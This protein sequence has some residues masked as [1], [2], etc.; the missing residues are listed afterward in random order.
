MLHDDGTLFLVQDDMESTTQPHTI[1]R[2]EASR[3]FRASK[4]EV[5]STSESTFMFRVVVPTSSVSQTLPLPEPTPEPA[6]AKR[7]HILQQ[8]EGIVRNVRSNT[9]QAVLAD[10]VDTTTPQEIAT[11]P[12]EDVAE[13]DRELLAPGSIFYWIIGYDTTHGGTKQRASLLRFQRLPV[14]DHGELAKVLIETTQ[15]QNDFAING[16]SPSPNEFDD[17]ATQSR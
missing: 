17:G 2:P 7:F 15:M 16:Q 11:F 10:L 1:T 12:I 9:F 13:A 14:W 5:P 3:A 8:W 6:A 4:L